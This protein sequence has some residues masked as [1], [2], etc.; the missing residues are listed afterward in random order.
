[1]HDVGAVIME[2]IERIPDEYHESV[3]KAVK[4][5]KELRRDR[6]LAFGTEDLTPS[7]FYVEADAVT[8]VKQVKFG[9]TTDI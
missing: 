4:I 1:M 7:E 9:R 5:S 2:N 3:S 6:E 8:A